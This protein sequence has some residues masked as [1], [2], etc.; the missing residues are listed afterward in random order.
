VLDRHD[1]D[2]ERAEEIGDAIESGDFSTAFEAVTP[3]M[4]D[5]F[6]IAGTP[7]TAAEQISGVLD[8]ADSFVAGS[9]LGPDPK[10]AV[11]LVRAALDDAT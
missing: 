8:Y 10:E 7:E 2:R 5:A 9:P 11:G 1:V 3:R 6:C 4:I